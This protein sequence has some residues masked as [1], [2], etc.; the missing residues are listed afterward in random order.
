[1][2]AAASTGVA[3][4]EAVEG[5]VRT[6]AKGIWACLFVNSDTQSVCCDETSSPAAP[7]R[8]A[9]PPDRACSSF[10]YDVALRAC[11]FCGGW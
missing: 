9:R 11:G 6:G 2:A 10:L 7:S 8:P 3:A 4:A 1:M 5:G